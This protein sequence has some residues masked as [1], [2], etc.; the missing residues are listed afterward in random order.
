MG[1]TIKDSRDLADLF[2]IYRTPKQENLHVVYTDANGIIVG[3]NAL[4]SG[5]LDYVALHQLPS[6]SKEIKA[7][8]ERLG[9]TKV[10]FLHNHPSGNPKLSNP[11]IRGVGE[12]NSSGL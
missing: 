9:A 2:Q 11:D 1:Q 6:L 8:A 12:D 7:K 4:T 3:H 5:A 10:H